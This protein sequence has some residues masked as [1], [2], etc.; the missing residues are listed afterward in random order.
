MRVCVCVG[1][2]V[3]VA[4]GQGRATNIFPVL[5]DPLL[6]ICRTRLELPER[7]DETRHRAGTRFKQLFVE[8]LR[9]NLW[10]PKDRKWLLELQE[11][12]E[13]PSAAAAT[14]TSFAVGN[15]KLPGCRFSS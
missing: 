15:R 7:T 13:A 11:L 10:S 12:W 4:W 8:V 5:Q 2:C 9:W 1:V 6:A 3:C 14:F